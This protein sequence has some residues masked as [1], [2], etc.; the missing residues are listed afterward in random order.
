MITQYIKIAWRNLW[1]NKL[2]SSINIVGLAVGLGTGILAMLYSYNEMNYERCHNNANQLAKVITYGNFGAFRQLPTTFPQAAFDL[3]EQFPEIKNAVRVKRISNNQ[4]VVFRGTEPILENNFL[5]TEANFFEMFTYTFS[6]GRYTGEANTIIL[7]QSMASKYFGTQN[8]IGEV[9]KIEIFGNIF[10]LKLEAIY[11]DLPNNTLVNSPAIMSWSVAKTLFKERRGY[12]DT[13]FDVYCQMLPNYD[14]KKLNTKIVADYKPSTQLD[15]FHIAL[16]PIKDFHLK[17]TFENNS[18][19]LYLLFIG[20]LIALLIAIFNY[21][22]QSTI[23]YSMRTQEVGIR[24]SNGGGRKDIF[25]QF[26]VDT[27]LTTSLAFG[28][29]LMIISTVLPYFNQLL[30]TDISLNAGLSPKLIVI[31]LFGL[32]VLLSGFYPAVVMSKVKASLLLKSMISP[33]LRKS[34]MR[35]VLTTVQFVFA[36]LLLQIMI[37]SQRQG[38]YMFNSDVCG[39]NA[40]NV[41]AI[42]GYKWGDLNKIKTELLRNTSVEA[43]SWGQNMPAMHTNMTRS[44]NGPN[45][46]RMANIFKCE[47]DFLN[48]F[49][50][51]ID[52]GRF[53]RRDNVADRSDGVVVNQLLV[54]ALAWDDPIGKSLRVWGQKREVIGV[55]SNYMAAPPI[56]EET[57]L[58]IMPAGNQSQN[59][60]IL[61]NPNNLK[62]AHQHI[63][64]VLKQAN[65]NYPINLMYYNEIADELAKTFISTATIVNAFVI[66]IIFNAFLSLFGLSHFIVERSKKQIGVKKVMGASVINVYW[67]LSKS[68]VIRFVVAFAIITPLSYLFSVQ[69]LSTFSRQLPL[70]ADIFIQSG[71]MVLVM[72]ALATGYKIIRTALENPVKALRY[73]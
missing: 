42:N 59:L 39:F 63:E 58:I 60:M 16:M 62:D 30:D 19:N 50:I 28:L 6:E 23:Q 35:N 20:G 1:R 40:D 7:S 55:V 14:I 46:Q 2:S 21:I 34:R 61:V 25:M 41:I 71:C 38:E 65:P 51:E 5:L 69:Y 44:W 32:T 48:V 52:K 56:F 27:F 66:V 4:V 53:Y 17:S 70:T 8:P 57:P 47:P 33:N 43:V 64:L 18:A 72:I 12:S 54:N 13:G 36:I 49:N 11:K 22:N 29:S 67:E 3:P 37:V 26:M 68:F 15:D 45:N 24:L 10:H 31:A 9:L 73:E